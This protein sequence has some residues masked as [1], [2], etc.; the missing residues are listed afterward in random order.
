VADVLKSVVKTEW[1]F[2]QEGESFVAAA[3]VAKKTGALG[4]LGLVGR[5]IAEGM[6]TDPPGITMVDD[7]IWAVSNRRLFLWAAD[8]VTGTKPKA[9]LGFAELGTEVFSTAVAER[10]PGAGMGKT[11]LTTAIRGVPVAVETKVGDARAL[12]DAI[13][14]VLPPPPP[15]PA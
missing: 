7:M 13:G 3:K 8:R 5:A 4:L 14:A 9:L 10:A 6:A 11:Y 1:Q 12:A 15:P 2:L